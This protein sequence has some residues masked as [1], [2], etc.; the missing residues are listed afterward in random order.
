MIT[1]SESMG[2]SASDCSQERTGSEKHENA[3]AN[4]QPWEPGRDLERPGWLK[5]LMSIIKFAL[6]SHFFQIAIVAVSIAILIVLVLKWDVLRPPIHFPESIKIAKEM[7]RGAIDVLLS[8]V[9]LQSAAPRPPNSSTNLVDWWIKVQSLLGLGTL[10]VAVFLWYGEVHEDWIN[11]M[12]KRM[13]V[14]FMHDGWPVIVCRYIWLAGEGDLR[15]WGQQVAAQAVCERFLN[16]YPNVKA[17][18]P[19]LAVWTDGRICRHYEVCF[20]LTDQNSFLERYQGMCSYQNMAAGSNEVTS[21]SLTDL[22][23]SIPA[24][25]FPFDWPKEPA[26]QTETVP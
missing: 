13:S 1:L 7:I 6:R 10:L 19:G 12:P 23:R 8:P 14:F 5:R 22:R 2:A 25:V 15:A 16:F 21:V 4:C 26:E 11:T 17:E 24:S 18:N 3:P 20:E 9:D